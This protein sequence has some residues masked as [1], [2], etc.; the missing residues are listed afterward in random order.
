MSGTSKGPRGD[1]RTV[2]ALGGLV[3]AVVAGICLWGLITWVIYTLGQSGGL[4]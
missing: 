3:L 2:E 4:D 1:E